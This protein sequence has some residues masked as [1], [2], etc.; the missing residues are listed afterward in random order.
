[1]S[2]HGYVRYTR[3][4][5]CEIC[6]D[7]K[8]AYMRQ[9]RGEAYAQARAARSRGERY[10]ADGIKHGLG[11]FQNHGCRCE[12]CTFAKAENDANRKLVSA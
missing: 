5:R 4:C 3:G 10:V 11:G 12:T 9:R 2:A 8:A 7:A 6:R 1:M